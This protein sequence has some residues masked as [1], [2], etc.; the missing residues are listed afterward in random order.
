MKAIIV[1]GTDKDIASLVAELQER[2][3]RRFVP[4]DAETEKIMDTTQQKCSH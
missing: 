1:E 2:Q 3:K 4:C